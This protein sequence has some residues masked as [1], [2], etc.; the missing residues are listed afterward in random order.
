[1]V[2]VLTITTHDN[3]CLRHNYCSTNIVSFICPSV[4]SNVTYS[5]Q[6][7]YQRPDRM[8][9]FGKLTFVGKI[10]KFSCHTS[11]PSSQLSLFIQFLCFNRVG[12]TQIMI[13][14]SVSLGGVTCCS[15]RFLVRHCHPLLVPHATLSIHLYTLPSYPTSL[16]THLNGE[17]PLLP[18]HCTCEPDQISS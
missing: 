2:C 18:I 1:M 11:Q 9:T 17:E 10:N 14:K 5:S 4:S 3:T 12:R 7:S 6:K 16:L 8:I 13:L 15:Y